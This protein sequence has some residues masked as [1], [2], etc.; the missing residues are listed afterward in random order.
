MT[1][2]RTP[3]EG[4]QFERQFDTG[5]SG[6]VVLAATR[7]KAARLQFI[8][9][10]MVYA[11][12]TAA[13]VMGVA[14]VMG[15]ESRSLAKRLDRNSQEV[16][17]V[18][19]KQARQLAKISTANKATLKT[20]SCLLLITPEERTEADLANCVLKVRE[21]DEKP[22]GGPGESTGGG[23]TSGTPTGGPTQS[24][25]NEGPQRGPQGNPPIE[26][27]EK[28]EPGGSP[29]PEPLCIGPLCVR[30]PLDPIDQRRR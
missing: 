3:Q 6:V 1:E 11:V 9:T 29:E 16:K 10:G 18:V 25:P 24:E 20:I 14:Y 15:G 7:A 8:W 22:S 21:K 13:L 19:N 17:E 23:M 26:K 5:D 27:P 2:P 12:M 28:P 4:E 30:P